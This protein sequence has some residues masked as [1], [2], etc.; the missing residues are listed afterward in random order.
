MGKVQVQTCA[1]CSDFSSC[2]IIQEWY[3]KKAA[4]YHRYK[5]SAE[6]IRQHGY[7]SFLKIADGWTNAVGR[8]E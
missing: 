5:I 7:D 1:D 4:K 3:K 2:A 6:Y 8:L